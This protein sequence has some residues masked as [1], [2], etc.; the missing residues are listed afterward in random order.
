MSGSA[1]LEYGF[2]STHSTNAVS[3]ALYSLLVINANPDLSPALRLTFQALAWIYAL[4]IVLG[5]LYCGMH[6]FLDISVGSALGAALAWIQW[7]Y[8]PQI[9][10]AIYSADV[11]FPLALVVTTLVLIRIHPEPADS[12]PCFDDGVAFAAVVIGIDIGNWHYAQTRWS[13]SDPIPAT[14]P[15][16]WAE[17]GLVKSVL[18]VV[19]GVAI[20]FAW[21]GV[22][23]P[24]L[25]SLLPPV[26]R[27]VEKTGLSIP[28]K[29]YKPAS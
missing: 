1:A 14:I 21:Q 25:H 4:S 7:R 27:L 10:A 13:V 15:F 17:I 28:R 23:K 5:R 26:F 24:T 18:R 22:A 6:G 9:D 29:D 12:C 16:S 2:P 20:I 8:E 11:M 19:I 3:V